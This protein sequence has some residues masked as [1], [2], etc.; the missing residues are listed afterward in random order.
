MHVLGE[1]KLDVHSK[2]APLCPERQKATFL[3]VNNEM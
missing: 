3:D 1:R 2:H